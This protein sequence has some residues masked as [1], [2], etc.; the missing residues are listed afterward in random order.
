MKKIFTLFFALVATIATMFAW[1]YEHVQIGELYY[2]LDASTQT[3]E[4]TYQELW[5]NDYYSSLGTITIPE[6]IEYNSVQYTITIIG[7]YAFWGCSGLT[8]VSVPNTVTRI[9]CGAFSG[10]W[11][12]TSMA[13]STNVTSIGLGAFS[14]CHSLVEI[15]VATDNSNYCSVDGVLFDKNMS[16]LVQCPG[17]KQGV[18]TIPNGVISLE[19]EAFAGCKEL[20]DVNIPNSVTSIGVDAF[21]YCT[22]LT[23]FIIPSSVTDIWWAAFQGCSNLKR[24]TNEVTTPQSI[25][26]D[27][28]DRVDKSTCT[29]YVPAESIDLYKTAEGWKD[30]ENIVAIPSTKEENV[31]VNYLN[32]TGGKIYSEQVTLML[33]SAPEIEGFTFLRWDVV[34]GQLA[35]GINIQAVYTA[36]SPTLAPDVYTNPA[37]SAQKLIRQGNVYILTDDHT[38]T[39]TGQIVK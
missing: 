14:N 4:V 24:I 6:L 11:G 28:F 1:D 39:I 31:K 13:I 16:T 20:T 38:Y 30:F 18:Y 37:N 27:V 15:E 22:G 7:D 10:C 25:A 3:A 36:D 21:Y 8:S 9:G 23:N 29:L 33:P 12:L 34:G 19:R 2:N 35:E 5:S 17:G 26:D 32:K